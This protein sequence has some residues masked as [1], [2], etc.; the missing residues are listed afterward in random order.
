MQGREPQYV[1]ICWERVLPEVLEIIKRRWPE[2]VLVVGF[3]VGVFFLKTVLMEMVEEAS[4]T[5]ESEQIVHSPVWASFLLGMGTMAFAIIAYMFLIGFL[6][7]ACHEGIEK[8]EPIDLLRAGRYFFWRMVRFEILFSI[9]WFALVMLF[10]A[11]VGTIVLQAKAQEGIPYWLF[12]MCMFAALVILIKPMLLAPAIMIARDK[13]VLDAVK[14][15]KQYCLKEAK[16]LLLLVGAS[17]LLMAGLSVTLSFAE[18]GT[19]YYYAVL[20]ASGFLSSALLL[21]IG[22][23]A[24]RFIAIRTDG[25]QEHINEQNTNGEFT[26]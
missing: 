1:Y 8:K 20:G 22:L 6:A 10:S 23:S 19:Y 26:E 7:T 15:L 13:M 12:Y 5:I 17:L 21:L 4:Q 14:L 11:I 18:I 9:L 16:N 3:Q 24:V 25:E 2:A